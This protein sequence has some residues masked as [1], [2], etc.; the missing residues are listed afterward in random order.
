MKQDVL[1][2]RDAGVSARF[3]ASAIRFRGPLTRTGAFSAE[4]AF[5]FVFGK[6]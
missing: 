6:Q 3:P 4:T 5:R 1:D 2:V